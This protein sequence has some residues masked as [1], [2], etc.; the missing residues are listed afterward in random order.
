LTQRVLAGDVV[1]ASYVSLVEAGRRVPTLD[2][3][4]HLARMLDV[5]VNALVEGRDLAALDR[6]GQPDVSELLIEVAAR[7][8]LDFNEYERA[9]GGLRM[10]LEQARA[11]GQPMRVVDLGLRLQ[12]AYAATGA[13][14]DRVALLEALLALP[15]SRNSA[16]LQVLIRSDLAAALREP[17]RMAEARQVADTALE[18]IAGTSLAETPWHVKLLGV[19]VSI[20]V[21]CHALERLEGLVEQLLDVAGHVD[22]PSVQGRA[23]WVASR[24]CALLRYGESAEQH[25]AD[26]QR[27]LATAAM[28]LR[29]WI[30]FCVSSGSVLLDIGG[31]RD[32]VRSWL[33]RADRSA[34]ALGIPAECNW[35]EML[36]ARYEYAC[37]RPEESLSILDSLLANVDALSA[38][39]AEILEWRLLQGRAMTRLRRRQPAERTLRQVAAYA[40]ALDRPD[41]AV[42]ARYELDAL[43]ANDTPSTRTPSTS[44]P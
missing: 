14:R 26:A 25:L 44:W 3:V 29:D 7:D 30:R 34:R 16:E 36:R 12:S 43:H 23:H 1:T 19:A 11:G 33:D 13:H 42:Q 10:A 38:T 6:G 22:R 28:P 39:P 31:D 27:T 21:E 17:G 40:E 2:V 4:V 5:P 37:E 20:L 15:L 24:A 9:A 18:Q 32:H 35:V 8:S 41:L